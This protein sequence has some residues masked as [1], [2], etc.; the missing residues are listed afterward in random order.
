MI[1]S[2]YNFYF[3]LQDEDEMYLVYNSFSNGLIAI[4]RE[5][6]DKIHG[7]EFDIMDPDDFGELKKGGFIVSGKINEVDLI[8]I[9]YRQSQYTNSHFTFTICPTL[10]CN[11]SCSYCFETLEN[12]LNESKVMNQKT[13][14]R[15]VASVDKYLE[16]GVKNFRAL[17]Y[18]G[19]PLLHPE[20]IE[21]LSTKF[22]E[23]CEKYKSHYS[24]GI[25]TNGTLL[26]ENIAIMLKKKRSI[27]Y[28]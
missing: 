18:G 16:N 21:E 27:Q 19:E 26:T 23:I 22:I 15:I 11:L 13:I 9:R 20:L 3:Q 8:K 28:K 14:N 2:K 24:S 12:N 10:N 5:L 4:S 7:K 1:E 25:I 6:K 17:W